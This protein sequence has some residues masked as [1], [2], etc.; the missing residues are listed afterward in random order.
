MEQV[1]Q[2]KK[3]RKSTPQEIMK[4]AGFRYGLFTKRHDLPMEDQDNICYYRGRQ[5]GILFKDEPYKNGE[6]TEAAVEAFE[7]FYQERA[8][9]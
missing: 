1:N 6:P 9:V 8:I 2:G 7:R 4:T 3:M 5:F